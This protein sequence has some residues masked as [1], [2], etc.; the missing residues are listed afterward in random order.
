M[1][2]EIEMYMIVMERWLR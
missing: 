2:N 1:D